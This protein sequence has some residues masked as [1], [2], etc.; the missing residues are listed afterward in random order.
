MPADTTRVAATTIIFGL[1]REG[2]T[3]SKNRH[4]LFTPID[5]EIL[6]EHAASAI[7][8]AVAALDADPTPQNE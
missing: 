2:A 1:A 6:D 8:A 7:S 3:T 5:E 4:A